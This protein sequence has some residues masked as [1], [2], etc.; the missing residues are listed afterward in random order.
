MQEETQALVKIEWKTANAEPVYALIDQ[1]YVNLYAIN[2]VNQKLVFMYQL[3]DVIATPDA[4]GYRLANE[5]NENILLN[6]ATT[7][8]QIRTIT[9]IM[10][11]VKTDPYGYISK[12]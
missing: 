5:G 3:V 2:G 10:S 6:Q 7:F 4:P 1:D 9:V 8:E 12:K 11:D